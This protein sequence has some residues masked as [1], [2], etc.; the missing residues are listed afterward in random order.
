MD[1]CNAGW[2][3]LLKHGEPTQEFHVKPEPSL[4]FVTR[5]I[6]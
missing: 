4:Y 2:H 1:V 5:T 3:M 6:N